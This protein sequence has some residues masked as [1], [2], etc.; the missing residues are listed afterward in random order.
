M[1]TTSATTITIERDRWIPF[2]EQFTRENRGA[3]A[4][5]EVI[6]NDIGDQVETGDRPFDGVSADLKGSARAVWITFGSTPENHFTHGVHEVKA[7]R[8]ILARPDRGDVFEVESD[9]GTKTLLTLSRPEDFA[10][11]PANPPEG[12]KK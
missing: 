10:L 4:T 3:H 2:M 12:T 11:P 7:V 9:D 8:V 5:L 6:R 1:S